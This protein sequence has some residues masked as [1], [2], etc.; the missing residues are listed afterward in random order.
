MRRLAGAGLTVALV[1]AGVSACAEDGGSKGAG[2]AAAKPTPFGAADYRGLVPGMA[3][4]AALASGALES[5]PVSLLDGCTDFTYKGG[6]APDAARMAAEAA[7]EAGYKDLN[8]KADALEKPAATPTLRPGASAKESAEFAA[9]ALE[10]AKNS[11]AGA[12]AIADATMALAQLMAAREA[13]DAAFLT[14][15]RVSFGVDGLRELVAPADARTAEGIGV[16]S[17]VEALKQAYDAKGLKPAK[18]GTFELPV[19]GKPGWQYEFT[20]TGEK[21]AS[22]ALANR[23]MKCA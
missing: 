22:V 3:K 8:A 7:A 15:G 23:T 2:A 11:A 13:R 20:V 9:A 19:E 5:V 17:T 12:K 1:V 16:G 21:V 14:A 10:S 4:D 6:P 18:G